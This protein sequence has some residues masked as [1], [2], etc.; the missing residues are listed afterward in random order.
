MNKKTLVKRFIIAVII[1]PLAL[2]AARYDQKALL[3]KDGWEYN[4]EDKK[5]HKSSTSFAEESEM[6]MKVAAID[7]KWRV[8]AL[9]AEFGLF[10]AF[11]CWNVYEK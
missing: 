4:P 10:K 7:F 5:Y 8:I 9:L 2:F 1:A 11:G 6:E 3:K